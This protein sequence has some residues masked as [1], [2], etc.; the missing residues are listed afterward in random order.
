[1]QSSAQEEAVRVVH[2]VKSAGNIS[3]RN[4]A[5]SRNREII[6]LLVR[7][8]QF[9]M[10]KSMIH[11]FISSVETHFIIWQCIH[12]RIQRVITAAVLIDIA[13]HRHGQAQGVSPGAVASIGERSLFEHQKP[14]FGACLAALIHSHLVNG[15]V[16]GIGKHDADGAI[17]ELRERS[18]GAYF[19][20]QRGEGPAWGGGG[21]I[22]ASCHTRS[23]IWEQVARL[24]ESR[25]PHDWGAMRMADAQ[26]KGSLQFTAQ[27]AH[28]SLG[29]GCSSQTTAQER[30]PPSCAAVILTAAGTVSGRK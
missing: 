6:T 4:R 5:S 24:S 19:D 2:H 7:S 15:Y 9:L 22:V 28:R 8:V 17:I 1:M 30:G 3:F 26:A 16:F 27:L 14:S 11:A 25:V 21:G 23:F 12:S 29:L 20:E 18:V 13:V 10:V